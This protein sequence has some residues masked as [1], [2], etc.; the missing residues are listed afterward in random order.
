M[1]DSED[2]GNVDISMLTKIY[3]QEIKLKGKDN[4]LSTVFFIASKYPGWLCWD[5]ALPFLS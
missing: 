4:I 1:L 3:C 5:R 2:A